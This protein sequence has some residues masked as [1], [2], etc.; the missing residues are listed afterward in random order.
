[1]VEDPNEPAFRDTIFEVLGSTLNTVQNIEVSTL[2]DSGILK[3]LEYDEQTLA[4]SQCQ[5]LNGVVG[6]NACR[7]I[8]GF[9]V[10]VCVP[11]ILGNYIGA[12]DDVPGCCGG[13][14]YTQ[15]TQCR[16][17]CQNSTG[18]QVRHN[19]FKI[20]GR[21][22]S[23]DACYTPAIAAQVMNAR[24]EFVCYDDCPMEE[25]IPETD[26]GEDIEEDLEIDV[27]PEIEEANATET[28]ATAVLPAK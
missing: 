7:S 13:A 15:T 6:A 23:W 18:V 4:N 1:M 2:G 14:C 25:E 12:I 26:L 21:Q 27:T 11:K 28:N 22:I 3:S 5:L 10:T 16:C 24:P 20:L 19:L 8:G 17:T 9:N